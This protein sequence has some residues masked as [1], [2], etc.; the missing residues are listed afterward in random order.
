MPFMASLFLNPF[1]YHWPQQTVSHSQQRHHQD[2]A[3][4]GPHHP[5][6]LC[7][8]SS[9][10]RLT[11]YVSLTRSP[12]PPSVPLLFPSQREKHSNQSDTGKSPWNVGMVNGKGGRERKGIW[13]TIWGLWMRS[14]KQQNHEERKR[15]RERERHGCC[16]IWP[17]LQI[18]AA[19]IWPDLEKFFFFFEKKIFPDVPD[20]ARSG[21]IWPN[22][23]DLGRLG[24]FFFPGTPMT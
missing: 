6:C 12:S 4:H 23:G 16:Q 19:Q 7:P 9:V 18:W 5:R 15:K 17:D 8:T 13:I 1:S 3:V 2:V 10:S 20:L 21:Q 11:P 14:T 24:K 22:L